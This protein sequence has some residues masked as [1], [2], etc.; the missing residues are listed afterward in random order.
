MVRLRCL[1]LRHLW[2]AEGNR[3]PEPVCRNGC[4]VAFVDAIGHPAPLSLRCCPDL[5]RSALL[6]TLRDEQSVIMSEFH[7]LA[8]P[9][10]V[11]LIQPRWTPRDLL[12]RIQCPPCAVGRQTDRRSP[13]MFQQEQ[14][15]SAMPT[16]ACDPSLKL[17]TSVTW[18]N[19][20]VF[21]CT[22]VRRFCLS[23]YTGLLVSN[24]DYAT[25][26]GD[27]LRSSVETVS[28]NRPVLSRGRTRW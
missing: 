15:H 17:D 12:P 13:M 8:L 7:R 1:V 5:Q 18:S 9:P 23:R 2:R 11:D 22:L 24:A 27:A 6:E 25:F 26:V 3:F 19:R 28:R 20:D 14:L 16:R 21:I 10:D 4:R